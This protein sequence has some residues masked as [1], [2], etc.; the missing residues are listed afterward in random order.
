LSSFLIPVPNTELYSPPL[1]L[2]SRIWQLSFHMNMSRPRLEHRTSAARRILPISERWK[3]PVSQ[4]MA[5]QM[6]AQR[7]MWSEG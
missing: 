6:W 2:P 5:W 7:Q 1:T 4:E 3:I